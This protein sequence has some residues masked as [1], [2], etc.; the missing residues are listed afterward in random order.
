MSM[1]PRTILY[2]NRGRHNRD[3]K[4]RWKRFMIFKRIA[5]R[6]K[7]AW[8]QFKNNGGVNRQKKYVPKIKIV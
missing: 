7:K 1:I 2:K 4:I 8:K 6:S 3:I 5:K